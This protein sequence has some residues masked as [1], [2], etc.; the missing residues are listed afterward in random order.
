MTV[1][2]P[3]NQAAE[4]F[5]APTNGVEAMVSQL[6][7]EIALEDDALGQLDAELKQRKESLKTQKT[8]LAKLLVQ[9]GVESVKLTNGL[10]PRVKTIRR[11]YKQKEVSDEEL[12]EWLRSEDLDGIIQSHVHFQTLQSTLAQHEEQGNAIPDTL[13][14]ATDELSVTMYG[15]SKFLKAK[16]N[17]Q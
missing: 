7:E 13:F 1:E 8:E 3:N 17:G 5:E 15:K 6:A 4:M 10:T 14:N 16:E 12:F 9:A 2:T 11:F